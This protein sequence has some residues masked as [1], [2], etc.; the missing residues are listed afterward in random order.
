MA[1]KL[2]A[3]PGY[4]ARHERVYRA[5]GKASQ[6]PCADSCGRRAKHWSQ[7]HGTTGLNPE[8][9][10]PRCVRCHDAYDGIKLPGL[11]GTATGEAHGSAKLTE[12]RVRGIFASVGATQREL[13]ELH[14]MHHTTIKDIRLGR[15]WKRVT[16]GRKATW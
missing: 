9:Y 13:A 5:R 2:K 4:V 6:H 12:A 7:I 1:P 16:D 10:E 14:G 11:G 15:L 8:H 3:L